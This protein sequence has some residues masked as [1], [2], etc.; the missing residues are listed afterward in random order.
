MASLDCARKQ[1][2]LEGES[3]LKYAI[4]LADYT[5]EEINK[6]PRFYCFGEEVLDGKGAMPLTL[7]K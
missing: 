3:L 1:I 7:L 4:T 2:A 5:R 6:I